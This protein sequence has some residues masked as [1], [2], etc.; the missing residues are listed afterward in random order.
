MNIHL[1]N[2]PSQI[3]ELEY[4]TVDIFDA[5]AADPY[6][7]KDV[8][9]QR[10]VLNKNELYEPG[11]N[12]KTLYWRFSSYLIPIDSEAY[13]IVWSAGR[14]LLYL[15]NS[16]NGIWDRWQKPKGNTV[17]DFQIMIDAGMKFAVY[18]HGLFKPKRPSPMCFLG[19]DS[20][21]TVEIISKIEKMILNG[22]LT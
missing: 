6:L 20:I 10:F 12:L 1:K 2:L 4:L 5:S 21:C 3:T 19:D 15:N 7:F 22:E 13:W 9:G 11:C 14:S 8:G 18:A 17:V 16:S